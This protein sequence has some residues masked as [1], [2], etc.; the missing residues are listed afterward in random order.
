MLLQKFLLSIVAL[1][2]TDI[3][4]G[5]AATHLRCGGILNDDII[6]NFYLIPRVK[7][8]ENWLTFYE[9]TR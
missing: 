6:T 9:V 5:S 4:Q 1:I 2:G 7:K 8:F 3:S